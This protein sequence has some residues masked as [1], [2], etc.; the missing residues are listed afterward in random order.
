MSHNPLENVA[1]KTEIH[2]G[3]FIMPRR[4]FYPRPRIRHGRRFWGGFSFRCRRHAA[5]RAKTAAHMPATAPPLPG[6]WWLL[7]AAG[8]GAVFW[9]LAIH[10]ALSLI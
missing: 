4:Y 5:T 9:A 10:A 2:S 6:G 3:I 8:L 1:S 7:P